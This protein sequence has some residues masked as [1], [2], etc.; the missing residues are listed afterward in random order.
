MIQ[1]Q[2]E[3]F[4]RKY[5]FSV[6]KGISAKLFGMFLTAI[7]IVI[8][9]S[10][11]ISYPIPN[12]P[13][14]IEETNLIKLEDALNLSG[15]DFIN[16]INKVRGSVG[17]NGNGSKVIWSKKNDHGLGLFVSANHVYGVDTWRSMNEE[18]IDLS[19]INNGIFIGS[20]LPP[21]DG[22]V[23]LT[24]E[25]IANFGFY[26][27]LIPSN[28]TNTTIHPKDDFYLG[29]IDNQ[30]ITDNGLGNYPNLIQV[31]VPLQM[32][33]P[34]KRTQ[35]IQTWSDVEDNEI[36]V[37]IGYPQDKIKYPNGAVS[38]GRIYSKTDAEKIIQSLKLNGDPEGDISYTP[39]VEFLANVEAVGG[40]SGGGVFN[41]DGQLLGIMVRATKLNEEPI[42][43]VIRITYIKQKINA[44]YNSLSVTDKSKIRPFISGELD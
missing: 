40:M 33:D 30:R 9:C 5:T 32:F 16:L 43:R 6:F 31:S 27:P 4:P 2:W 42:L 36:V 34:D 18:F 20:K 26:H 25:L 3:S 8:G 7:L 29:I 38:R 37:A 14:G 39:E 41:V 22:S 19:A 10:N 24:N 44:F 21:K 1:N 28:A 17:T 35:A 13:T 12:P 23:S 11:D 15:T